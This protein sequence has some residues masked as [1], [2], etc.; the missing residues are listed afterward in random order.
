VIPNRRVSKKLRAIHS[1]HPRFLKAKR[2]SDRFAGALQY[3]LVR[4]SARSLR[5]R[6]AYCLTS[7]GSLADLVAT[8]VITVAS[9]G[10]C[11]CAEVR[12]AYRA[13]RPPLHRVPS[14]ECPRAADRLSE[15]A[16][17]LNC[18]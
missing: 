13:Y 16:E 3:A 10:I 9:V 4:R 8:S 7:A 12:E 5:V 18:V 11:V 1:A 6:G 14:V 15:V 17:C 2:A